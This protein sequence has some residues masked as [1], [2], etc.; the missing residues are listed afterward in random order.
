MYFV[1]SRSRPTAYSSYHL[2]QP[3]AGNPFQ[4]YTLQHS[5]HPTQSVPAPHP[6]A[7]LPSNTIRSSPH[8]TAQLSSNTIRSSPTPYSTVTIQ[9][10]PFQP[11]TLQHSYHPTQSIPAPHPKTQLPSN[12]IHSSPTPY[13]TVTIQHNPFQPHTL[14]KSYH[15]TQSI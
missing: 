6:T 9:H 11:H 14:Q 12:T 15:P 4:S 5:C 13:N 10:N 2:T 1:V 7:Q 3:F 8:P